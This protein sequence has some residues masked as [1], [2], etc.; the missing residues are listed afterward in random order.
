MLSVCIFGSRARQTA[1]LI[2]DRDVL[3]VGEPSPSMDR[4]VGR[5]ADHAWNVSVFHREAFARLAEVQSLFVQHLKQEGRIFRDDGGFLES[6]LRNYAPKTDYSAERN[7]A[8][9][10]I[11][12]LPST[13]GGYWH[14][15]CLADI[16]FVLFRNAAILHLASIGEYCFHYEKLVSRIVELL[17]LC[18]DACEPLLALRKLKHSYRQRSRALDVSREF[19][20][21]RQIILDLIECLPNRT[22][23]SIE[24]GETTDEYFKMRLSELSLVANDSP[25]ILDRLEPDSP[26]FALWQS[27]RANGGY[28]KPRPIRLSVA[29]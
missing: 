3:V 6:V 11:I 13:T 18:S 7:D 29:H 17:N 15:L 10:Q 22:E 23:S 5:W 2:S 9:R 27:I 4:V 21:A 19:L 16:L 26:V 8:M 20:E 24:R 14:D 25:E 12:A 28:P 1:D